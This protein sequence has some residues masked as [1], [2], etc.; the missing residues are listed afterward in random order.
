G[1]TLPSGQEVR[2]IFR[3]PMDAASLRAGLRIDPPVGS[4]PLQVSDTE[5][6]LQPDLRPSM[7][8]T[9]TVGADTPDRSGEPL[10]ITA[11]VRLT[12]AR[13][14]P[15]LRAPDATAHVIGLP[16]SRTAQIALERVNLSR[17]DLSLYR[18]DAPTAVRAMDLAP[19][20]WRDFSP[21]RYGQAMARSWQLALSDPVD[22]PARDPIT[23]ALADGAPLAAGIYYLR[24]I[25]Q[26][27]P[28]ADLLL[29]VSPLALTLRQ[30]DSQ[31]LVWATDSASGA[32]APG[33]PLALYVGETL[34]TRGQTGP[35]GVWRQPIQRPAGAAPYLALAEGSAPTL[36]RG[37]WLAARPAADAPRSRSLIF[38][39]RLAYRPGDRVQI[40]GVARTL[41]DGAM[42]LPADD[43]PCRMQLESDN[44]AAPGPSA[45]CAVSATGAVS[46]TLRLTPQQPAGDYRLLVRIG[47]ST[48][49]LSLRVSADATQV[50]LSVAPISGGHARILASQAG[51]P[52]VGATISWTLSLEPLALPASREGFHF[53]ADLAAPA[54]ISGSGTT[55]TGGQL[56]VPL[57][58]RPAPESTL[59]Y[60]LRAELSAASEPSASDQIA[61]LIPPAH[62]RV[63]VRLPTRIVLG[64]ER[65][66]VDLLAIAATGT[67]APGRLIDVAVYRR[68]NTDGPPLIARSA[69]S[70]AQGRASVQLVQL[71]AGAYEIVASL[72]SSTSSAGL[73]VAGGRY[74]G[75]QGAPGQVEVVTDRDSYRPGDVARLLVTSP[76]ADSSLLLTTERG[77]LRSAEVRDLRAS[78]LITLA[79]T[80]DMAPAISIGAVVSAGSGRLA[81][82]TA[83]HVT[84]GLPALAVAVAADSQQYAP[85]GTA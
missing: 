66:T 62:D 73:W 61:G 63:G 55:D 3:T 27:G 17:L 14:A 56:A 51:L 10:G 24:A 70:D 35:D 33:V 29:A 7:T 53:A 78:Q 80:P 39:D 2:L 59:R 71:P 22:V 69:T 67:P 76:Y 5:V 41:A 60:R 82:G 81:G 36:V 57:P 44:P 58:A 15:S 31:V 9:L 83:I 11:T 68:G 4:L 49:A 77:T 47:D 38:L 34:L 25:T 28:R 45:T 74:V 32:P 79:I 21:E 26:E 85:A 40:G 1:Q 42:A 23:V 52:L 84:D 72:G 12:A 30:S 48:T 43:T 50:S 16:I 75:W 37:D 6:R 54:L 65:A 46:G 64:D 18:L 19:D 13:A 8:Y 20:E